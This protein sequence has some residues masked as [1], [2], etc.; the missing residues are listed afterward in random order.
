M[1]VYIAH[2]VL[3]GFTLANDC[4]FIK[5]IQNSVELHVV[6]T[7]KCS[8]MKYHFVFYK[9]SDTQF[10]LKMFIKTFSFI[11]NLTICMA[12]DEKSFFHLDSNKIFMLNFNIRK[13]HTFNWTECWLVN[14]YIYHQLVKN[15]VSNNKTY[16]EAEVWGCQRNDE[17][18]DP[19]NKH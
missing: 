9:E 13:T 14:S 1:L 12:V 8:N 10:S 16:I 19:Y 5:L 18:N 17:V 4:G 11:I 2:K 3:E 15:R 7:A 6:E